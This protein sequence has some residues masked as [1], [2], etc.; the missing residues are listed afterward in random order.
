MQKVI[1]PGLVFLACCLLCACA[2]LSERTSTSA[3]RG[4]VEF[5]RALTAGPLPSVTV[6]NGVVKVAPPIITE[7]VKSDAAQNFSAEASVKI[8]LGT[9]LILI[10]VGLLLILSSLGIVLRSSAAARAV[11]S[12]A[13]ASVAEAIRRL[14]SKTSLSTDPARTAELS[15]EIAELESLRGRLRNR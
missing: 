12:T 1:Q 15:V 13:D 9:K 7:E 8:P 10:G 2:G 11:A 4:N 3:A 14:R 6:S 5:T